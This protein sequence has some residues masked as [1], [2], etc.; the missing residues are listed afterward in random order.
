MGVILQS[1]GHVIQ[2][3]LILLGP[4]VGGMGAARERVWT[5]E[6]TASIKPQKVDT[7]RIRRVRFSLALGRTKTN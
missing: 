2:V 7:S 1:L 3:L 4:I 6:S 5:V